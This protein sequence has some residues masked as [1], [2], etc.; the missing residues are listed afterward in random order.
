VVGG[1]PTV[2]LAVTVTLDAA[3]ESDAVSQVPHRAFSA[4]RSRAPPTFR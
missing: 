2:V 4:F 3:P 1:T